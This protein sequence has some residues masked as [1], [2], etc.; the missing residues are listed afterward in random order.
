MLAR[1]SLDV[2]TSAK[3]LTDPRMATGMLQGYGMKPVYH[4]LRSRIHRLIT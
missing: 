2:S 4:R 1:P 3:L